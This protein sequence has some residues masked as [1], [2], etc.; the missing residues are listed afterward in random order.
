LVLNGWFG[1]H[2]DFIISIV[3]LNLLYSNY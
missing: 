2:D 3:Y 1:W